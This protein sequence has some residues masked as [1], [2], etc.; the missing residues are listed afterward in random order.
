M[1]SRRVEVKIKKQSK[2]WEKMQL[3]WQPA[4]SETRSEDNHRS[5]SRTIERERE[6]EEEASV[7]SGAKSH[8][9]PR[10]DKQRIAALIDERT[11][12]RPLAA[13]SL[14]C[15]IRGLEKNK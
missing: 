3:G 5:A 2:L 6:R 15:I 10:L 8:A 14:S 12:L 4:K 1:Q 11:L 13:S 7:A 9:P